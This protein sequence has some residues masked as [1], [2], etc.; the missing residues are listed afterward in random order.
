MYL[1][2]VLEHS[3]LVN[4]IVLFIKRRGRRRNYLKSELYLL[5]YQLSQKFKLLGKDEFNHLTI[6]LTVLM[7]KSLSFHQFVE[8]LGKA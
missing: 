6:S 2:C 3:S 7:E 5:N 4:K 8:F 1:S